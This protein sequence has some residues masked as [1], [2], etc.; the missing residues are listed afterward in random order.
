MAFKYGEIHV[1]NT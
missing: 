1:I